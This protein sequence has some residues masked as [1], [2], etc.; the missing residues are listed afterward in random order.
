M[1]VSYLISLMLPASLWT[2][3]WILANGYERLDVGVSHDSR[4]EG[5]S[6]VDAIQRQGL[7]KVGVGL[8]EPWVMCDKSGDLIGYEID[9]AS[10]LAS[11]IGVRIAFVRTDWYYI[12][13]ALIEDRF[14]LVISGMGITPDRG[15]LVNFT[16]P[17]SEFGTSVV[18]NTNELEVPTSLADLNVAEVTFGARA[19]SVPA[20]V[21]AEH[22]PLAS[23]Q[24]FDTDQE[25]LETLIAAGAH[26]VAVDQI[27]ASRWTHEYPDQLLRPFD[28][29][30]KVPEAIALRKQDFD[31]LNFLNGWIQHYTSNGWLANRRNYWFDTREW[32]DLLPDDPELIERCEESFAAPY[33]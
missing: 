28:L 18:I 14:D 30:N 24:F 31:G 1:K 32:E 12:V 13:P 33:Q 20:Q 2:V 9:V 7:L 15:L 5:S 25:M 8:F 19:G 17:Y 26:A 10:Q 11:D 3:Q 6:V 27:N 4:F 16:I 21:I 23:V 22:F 29:L